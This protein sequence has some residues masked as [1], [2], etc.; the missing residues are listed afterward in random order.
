MF[1]RVGVDGFVGTA[2][3]RQVS[4]P[5]TVQ[6]ESAQRNR[7]FYRALKDTG[8]H[9]PPLP[10]DLAGLPNLDREQFHILISVETWIS[11]LVIAGLCLMN[12]RRS[13]LIVAATLAC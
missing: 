5:V 4:L 8:S 12:A 13:A 10:F 3:D 9:T 6:V 11:W 1:D 2:V 7:S